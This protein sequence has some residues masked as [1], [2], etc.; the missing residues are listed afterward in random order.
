[1]KIDLT[2]KEVF[3]LLTNLLKD[4]LSPKAFVDI[5][6]KYTREGSIEMRNFYAEKVR[7]LKRFQ[8]ILDKYTEDFLKDLKESVEYRFREL[9]HTYDNPQEYIESNY[10]ALIAEFE[11]E[12]FVEELDKKFMYQIVSGDFDLADEQRHWEPFDPNKGY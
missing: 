3:N 12:E 10:A 8:N 7:R 9:Y 2:E 4:T 6:P 11:L 1:M 5:T